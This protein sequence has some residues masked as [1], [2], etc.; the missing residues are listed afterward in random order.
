MS[1]SKMGKS[2]KKWLLSALTLLRNTPQSRF[3]EMGMTQDEA[4]EMRIR[5]LSDLTQAAVA[6]GDKAEARRLYDEFRAAAL[7]RSPEQVG[8]MEAEQRKRIFG[9]GR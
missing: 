9:G 4:R 6:A 5:N 3:Y 8:R 7:A 2:A 1:L